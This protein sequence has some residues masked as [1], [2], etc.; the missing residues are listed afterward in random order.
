MTEYRKIVGCS[1][2]PEINKQMNLR[3][4]IL[5]TT[6]KRNKSLMRLLEQCQE[7]FHSY[8]SNNTYQIC[9]ADSDLNNPIRQQLLDDSSIKYSTNP[10]SGLDD[11]LF[12][13]WK[14]N[15]E[16]YDYIFGIP[17]DAIFSPGVNPLYIIDAAAASGEDIVIFNSRHSLTTRGKKT[18]AKESVTYPELLAIEDRAIQSQYFCT[19]PF[20]YGFTLYSTRALKNKEKEI[21]RF[22]NAVMYWAPI[23]FAALQKKLIFFPYAIGLV[24]NLPFR[25]KKTL[26]DGAWECHS[27]VFNG[28]INF[29]TEAKRVLPPI[30]YNGLE[31]RFLFSLFDKNCPDGLGKRLL[32][33]A[34]DKTE[35]QVRS[36]LSAI[37]SPASTDWA[38][39]AK[40]APNAVALRITTGLGTNLDKLIKK[41]ERT[42][43]YPAGGRAFD[44][45]ATTKLNFVN[46]LA[47]SDKNRRKQATGIMGYRV[48][49][50]E[51]ILSFQPEVVL[52]VVSAKYKKEILAELAYLKTHGIRVIA[53]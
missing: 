40:T 20:D 43:V 37:P 24:N 16:N 29:L 35:E 42:I 3:I 13:F 53:I 10:G 51:S 31:R 48:I 15:Y 9:V 41:G 32:P 36:M 30:F 25:P 1:D 5:I 12:H 38:D 33:Q 27:T 19:N 14:S 23:F 7:I 44:L 47:L 49:P 22:R 17:D 39:A 50:P 18:E 8:K 28:Q 6:Y 26:A 52:V 46:I 21:R 4:C 45:L 2:N 11:N 34:I